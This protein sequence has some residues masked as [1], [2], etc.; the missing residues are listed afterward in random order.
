M[1]PQPFYMHQLSSVSVYFTKQSMKGELLTTIRNPNLASRHKT[2]PFV[3][4]FPAFLGVSLHPLGVRIEASII[5]VCIG[6]W[7]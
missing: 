6:S 5:I 3:F 7:V 1:S 2:N 4:V